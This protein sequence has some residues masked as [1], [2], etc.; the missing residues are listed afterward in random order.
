M[1]WNLL[2]GSL[3][4]GPVHAAIPNHWL[5]VVLI[6][7]AEGWSERETLS[8]VTLSGFFHTL[9]TVVLGIVI[10][11]VG[12]EVSERMEERTRLIAS[13]L[14]VF[15]GLI[16]FAMHDT[17]AGTPERPHEH[18]PKGLTGRSKVSIVMTLSVAM[19]FSPCLEIE[20]FFFTAGT[21][22]WTAIATLALSYT[23]VTIACMVGLTSVSYR[24]LARVNWHWLDRYEKR[25][26]G[27]V[28]IILGILIFFIKL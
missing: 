13:L 11:A 17:N 22:G 18:V 2:V 3:L 8:V 12:V 4:L 16:Y 25:I 5:P 10:G 27:S 23:V 14:L 20:P 7:R 9:S 19:L 6:G 28:L 1:F 15:M 24:G 21:L 26:T